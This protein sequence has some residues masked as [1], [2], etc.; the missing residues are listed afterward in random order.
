MKDANTEPNVWW[1]NNKAMTPAHFDALHADMM[2]HAEGREL[3]AKDLFGGADLTHRIKVRVVTEFALALLVRAS[4]ADP[5]RR[6]R[7]ER[8][9]SEFTIIDLP[10]FSSDP[11]KNT[12]PAARR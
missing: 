9:R 3:F 5:P 4:V 12:A 7:A 1:D 8:L 2:A 10:S 6:R 11:K